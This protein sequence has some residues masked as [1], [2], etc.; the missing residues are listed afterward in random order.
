MQRRPQQVIH[1]GLLRMGWRRQSPLTAKCTFD[2]ILI[3]RN[4]LL[5]FFLDGILTTAN[6]L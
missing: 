3:R 5:I 2:W 6:L 1:L 4:L